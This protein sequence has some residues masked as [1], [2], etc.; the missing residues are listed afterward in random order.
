MAT[1]LLLRECEVTSNSSTVV[2]TEAVYDTATRAVRRS[3]SH[4]N[5]CSAS[6]RAV[7]D[8]VDS[9]CLAPGVPP[10]T[11]RKVYPAW[12]DA[13]GNP[14]TDPATAVTPAGTVRFEDTDG[15]GACSVTPG[16]CSL[17]A[18]AAVAAETPSRL[19]SVLVSPSG[20][21][22][23]VEYSLDDFQTSN[24]P[25]GVFGDLPAGAYL[26]TVREVR[27]GGCTARVAFTIPAA[28]GLRYR[29]PFVA[30][31]GQVCRADIYLRGYTGAVEALRGAG[32][33]SVVL[34]WPGSATDHLFT[35]LLRGSECELAILCSSTGQLADLY[36]SDERRARVEIYRAGGLVWRGWLLPEQWQ[37]PLLAPP[38]ASIIRGTDGLGTL[39]DRP[40]GYE[41]GLSLR[42]ELI[43]H[44]DTIRHC[45][46]LAGHLDALPIYTVGEVWSDRMQTD[47]EA[48][49][50]TQV[51]GWTNGWRTDKNALWKAGDVLRAVLD[52]YQLRLYQWAGAWHIERL[53]EFSRR[54][55][56]RR[57]AYSAAGVAG[58]VETAYRPESTIAPPDP[59][60]PWVLHWVNAAQSRTLRPAV[61]EVVLTNNENNPP[62][63]LLP[64]GEGW[65]AIAFTS[66]GKLWQWQGGAPYTRTIDPK[67]PEASVL[68]IPMAPTVPYTGYL[69]RKVRLFD[70]DLPHHY[71]QGTGGGGNY[72]APLMLY[73]DAETDADPTGDP[74]A[75]PTHPLRVQIFINGAPGI[76]QDIAFTQE[77]RQRAGFEIQLDWALLTTAFVAPIELEIRLLPRGAAAAS[78]DVA[79]RTLKLVHGWSEHT[80]KE[81]Q[82]GELVLQEYDAPAPVTAYRAKTAIAHATRLDA[83]TREVTEPSELG[84]YTYSVS[85]VSGYHAV[86]SDSP[87]VF[88]RGAQLIGGGAVRR[89]YELAD[90]V[91]PGVSFVRGNVVNGYLESGYA[92]GDLVARDRALWQLAP[93]MCLRGTLDGWLLQGPGALLSDPYASPRLFVQT[94][95]RLNLAL[96]RWDVTAVEMLTARAT[97]VPAD[98]LLDESGANRTGPYLLAEDGSRLL[99]EDNN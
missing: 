99:T 28:Y 91:D 89:W 97:A 95:T 1:V 26:A 92:M 43:S 36:A 52:Y 93:A 90:A 79:I 68:R 58:A 4:V 35:P 61:R 48:D 32:A 62:V 65:P 73:V 37:E 39:S 15:V 14:T 63:N 25:G 21:V 76:S 71:A 50:L 57:I 54:A 78:G 47:A 83:A 82:F 24:Q 3:I 59:A 56:C 64:E 13:A 31:D 49:F 98:A 2:R 29:L 27:A 81:Y 88:A 20:A 85:A 40:F 44:L 51:G 22:G 38:F 45:L 23:A 75:F 53:S 87:T 70:I 18:R 74:L 55:G 6:A 66:A 72:W 67:K 34:S 94:D 60:A 77:K 69:S 9:Y 17:T 10:F 46:A 19:G 30:S 8:L 42:P 33:D 84:S 16:G 96:S 86:K 41:N 12:L 11:Q 7:G 80:F 5:S